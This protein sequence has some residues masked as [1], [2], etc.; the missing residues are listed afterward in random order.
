MI[1]KSIQMMENSWPENVNFKEI[2]CKESCD[3]MSNVEGQVVV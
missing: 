1:E 3:N 2:D